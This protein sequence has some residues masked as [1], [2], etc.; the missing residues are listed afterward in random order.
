MKT[1]SFL[2]VA[3]TCMVFHAGEA[4]A[5][6]AAVVFDAKLTATCAPWDGSALSIIV[7]MP[8][9]HQKFTAMVWGQGLVDLR[10][11]KPV[12]LISEGQADMKSAGYANFC[13][14]EETDKACPS[15][16]AMIQLPVDDKSPNFSAVGTLT[17]DLD[18]VSEPLGRQIIYSIR[19]IIQESHAVCG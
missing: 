2:M 10:A 18:P 16:N 17:L 4:M 12:T 19:P 7:D 6:R 13:Q 5:R 3:T 1:L 11:G 15:A 9:T 8:Q 14:S